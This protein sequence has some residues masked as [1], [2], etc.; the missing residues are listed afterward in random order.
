[1]EMQALSLP[2]MTGSI[3][4]TGD[5][6][7]GLPGVVAASAARKLGLRTAQDQDSGRPVDGDGD[8]LGATRCV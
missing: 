3:P 5:I 8:G 2:L 1:M 6:F 4:E 7:L